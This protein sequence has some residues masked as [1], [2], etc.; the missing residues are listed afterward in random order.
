MYD[1]INPF[2][3]YCKIFLNVVVTI[4]R[5]RNRLQFMMKRESTVQEYLILYVYY[6]TI[7]VFE[8]NQMSINK[9]KGID[10]IK[11]NKMYVI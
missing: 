4:Y 7:C 9:K 3:E 5:T 1:V 10:Y 8:G 6:I 2:Y 11:I